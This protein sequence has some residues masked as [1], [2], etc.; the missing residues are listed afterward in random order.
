MMN[1]ARLLLSLL[2]GGALG[3]VFFGGL[4][5]TVYR[6]MSSRYLALWFLGS[7]VLRTGFVM[8]GFYLAC[9]E[10]WQCWLAALLGFVVARI[11]FT[12][13]TNPIALV[14]EKNDA[15]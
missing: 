9:G 13:I 5:W 3:A 6:A 2:I 1:E 10:D 14:R 15:P 4:C 12:R 11:V 7:L 8:A